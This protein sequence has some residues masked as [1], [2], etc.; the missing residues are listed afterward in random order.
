MRMTKERTQAKSKIVLHTGIISGLVKIATTNLI[1]V[2]E[3]QLE[4]N[5]DTLY[6]FETRQFSET[7]I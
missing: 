1:P 4:G 3:R 2:S 5:S 7:V 6:A